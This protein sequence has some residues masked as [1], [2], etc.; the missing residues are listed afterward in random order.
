MTNYHGILTPI[1]LGVTGQDGEDYNVAIQHILI[2]DSNGIYGTTGIFNLY[3][4]DFGL[5]KDDFGDL[6]GE[7]EDDY[8]L[9]DDQ[10]P[11]Y[12]GRIL[13]DDDGNWIY[14]GDTISIMEQEQLAN[15]LI[16]YEDDM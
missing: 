8:D 2:Q 14:D 15:F 6:L 11:D 13:F 10:N 4:D 9:P 16:N 12:L 3:K 7:R 5:D 1:T